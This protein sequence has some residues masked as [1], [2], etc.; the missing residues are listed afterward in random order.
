MGSTETNPEID[1]NAAAS[2]WEEALIADLR[3]NNGRPSSGPL[4]GQPLLL[5]WSTGAKSGKQRRSILTYSRDGQDY[6]VAGSKSGAPTHPA[7]YY[8]VQAN[9][10]VTVEIGTEKFAATATVEEGAE[11]DRLW[12]QHVEQLPRFGDYPAQTGGRVIPTIRLRRH[13]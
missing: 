11:R 6:V 13:S 8:N 10:E 4:A 5:L 2:A 12:A 3:A 9:P 7:W 1:A